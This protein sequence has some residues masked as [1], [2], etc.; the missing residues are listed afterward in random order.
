MTFTNYVKYEKSW[1]GNYEYQ[2]VIALRIRRIRSDAFA[3]AAKD[4]AK[5]D[6]YRYTTTRELPALLALARK[7][8]WEV[9]HEEQKG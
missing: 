6:G 7:H 8:G 9:I 4:Q 3:A 2:K 1:F 5:R